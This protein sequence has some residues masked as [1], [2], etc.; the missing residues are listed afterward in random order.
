MLWAFE[1]DAPRDA[2]GRAVLPDMGQMDLLGITRRPG[3][4]KF[5]VRE[6]F[7][8]ARAIIEREAE[9]AERALVAWNC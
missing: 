8:G 2:A 9:E 5:A 6:R 7:P 4:F 3:A 1:L